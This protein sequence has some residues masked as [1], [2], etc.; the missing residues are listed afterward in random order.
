MGRNVGTALIATVART[1]ARDALGLRA[2][3]RGNA[4][5]RQMRITYGFLGF[6]AIE[7][8]GDTVVYEHPAP[9][10]LA[11]PPYIRVLAG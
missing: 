6:K 7:R 3:Y 2:V 5:N 11:A 9:A 8:Q 1:A 10:E 4:R